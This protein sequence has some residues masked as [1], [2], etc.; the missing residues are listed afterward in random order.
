MRRMTGLYGSGFL[1][2]ATFYDASSNVVATETFVANGGY[3]ITLSGVAVGADDGQYGRQLRRSD[4]PGGTF[5]GVA[6]ASYD[7]AYTVADS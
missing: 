2:G 1:T 5:Q 7:L 4:L 3:A 6:Y